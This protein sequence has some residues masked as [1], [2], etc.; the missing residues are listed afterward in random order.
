MDREIEGER[1]EEMYRSVRLVTSQTSWLMSK[2]GLCAATMLWVGT[3]LLTRW[4]KCN[5]EIKKYFQ[6]GKKYNETSALKSEAVNLDLNAVPT[7]SI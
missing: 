2:R 5:L 4:Q 3:D 1:E 6:K 7:M